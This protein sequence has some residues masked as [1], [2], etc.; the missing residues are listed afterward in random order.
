MITS[1]DDRVITS[2]FCQKNKQNCGLNH[3]RYCGLESTSSKKTIGRASSAEAMK[4]LSD[5]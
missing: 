4:R 3:T 2:G 5:N 1:V